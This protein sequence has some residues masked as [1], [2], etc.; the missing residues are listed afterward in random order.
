MRKLSKNPKELRS[1]QISLER[2]LILF[3]ALTLSATAF[4][5]FFNLAEGAEL[6][7]IQISELLGLRKSGHYAD[8]F[9]I[10]TVYCAT[11]RR[12][13]GFED[14]VKWFGKERADRLSYGTAQLL[15]PRYP[16]KD[17]KFSSQPDQSIRVNSSRTEYKASLYG[18]ARAARKRVMIYVHGFNTSWTHAITTA[19]RLNNKIGSGAPMVAFIW[20]SREKLWQ[21]KGDEDEIEWSSNYLQLVVSDILEAAQIEHVDIA[22]HSMG[23]RAVVT[24]LSGIF[25]SANRFAPMIAPRLAL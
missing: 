18:K 16:L 12:P 21:Y 23:A 13:T 15:L 19:A 2:R 25:K 1:D 17:I 20:P 11:N 3:S 7:D 24:A 9:V 22:A 4:P 10:E 14:A 8:Q 6:Q 5:V